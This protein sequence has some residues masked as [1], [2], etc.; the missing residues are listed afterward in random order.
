MGEDRYQVRLKN[1]A[2]SE[3]AGDEPALQNEIR[4]NPVTVGSS[5][6]QTHM[7]SRLLHRE[8]LQTALLWAAPAAFLLFFYFYPLAAVFLESWEAAV[9]SSINWQRVF[10][11][12][13]FTLW[14][15]IL[16]TI[17]TLLVGL[18]AAYLFT[19]YE[20]PLKSVLKGMTTL[21]FILPT[22]VAAAAINSLYGP[23]G[24][25][26]LGW[27]ALT[28]T[29][30]P[31]IN[32]VNSL[33]AILLAHVFYNTAVIIRVT[34]S[35]WEKMDSRLPEAA[36]V[37]GASPFKAL[38]EITLPLLLPSIL[39]SSVLVFMFD[40]TSFGVILMLGGPGFSTLE[41]E[42][43]YQALQRLNLPMASIISIIQLVCTIM[44]GA[45]YSRINK[46]VQIPLVPRMQAAGHMKAANFRQKLLLIL[47][48]IGLVILFVLPL[49]S[50]AARSVTRLEAERGQR[51]AI[52]TGLTLDYYRELFIN[53]RQ[54]IFYV[55]PVKAAL[56]SVVYAAE[57]VV[58]SGILGALASLALRRRNKLTR[59]MDTL[60]MLPLGTSAVTLGLGY[61]LVFNRP[62]LDVRSF[63]L[64]IP[65]AHSLVALPFV[66]RT[67]A[68]AL[69]SIPDSLRQAA[70]T[71]G[72]NPMRIWLEV[73]W[74]I[75]ARSALV[76]AIFSFTIS[77]GEFGATTFLAR[78]EMPTLPVAIFRFLSQPGALNY[79][80]AMAMATFLMVVC[81]TGILSM[82]RMKVFSFE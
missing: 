46:A 59:F 19:H 26:N 61:L 47:L 49:T 17:L 33:A 18:P 78:P 55:P 30:T 9:D 43:Y 60:L 58:I 8:N 66:I 75:M 74:P 69:A 57:T 53:R 36:R 77:L 44:I 51:T 15:A 14:Q 32:I 5:R 48:V 76:A 12:L 23:R 68:P 65:I 54:S 50:L 21:P 56:N 1:A 22:V 2:F 73:D 42:V 80:Q 34:G 41:T 24:W 81:L 29:D 16:S 79:G 45:A 25:F 11:P 35:A 27:M 3:R 67:I 63:T 6:K 38:T 4:T 72:A 64:F 20:F 13:G 40:F 37:L 82:E 62:P 31:V 52:N 10:Q 39:A 7:E 71:L 70:A 28:G